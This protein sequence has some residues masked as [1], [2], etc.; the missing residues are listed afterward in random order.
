M[1]RYFFIFIINIIAFNLFAQ[2]GAYQ[3]ETPETKAERLKW[4]TDA[5][6]GMFIHW[7]AYSILDGEFGGKIQRDPKGEWIM[8]NLRIPIEDYKKEVVGKF[9]PS[10]F[11]AEKWVFVAKASGMKYMVVTAKHH[12]GFALFDS[13]VSDYDIIDAT[14]FKRDIIKELAE[15]CHR[16]G[17]RFGIYYSQAQDWYQPGGYLPNNRWDDG[18]IGNWNIYFNKIVKGQITELFTGYGQISILWWDSGRATQNKDV[19]DEVGANLVKLQPDIIVNNRLGG[20]LEGDFKTHEQQIPALYDGNEPH[21][22]CM[23]HNR[24]WSYRA[25]DNAWKSP[26]FI[27]KTLIHMASIGGNF[28]FNVGAQPDGEFP[29]ETYQALDYVGEWMRKNGEAIYGTSASPFYRLGWG[30]CTQKTVDGKTFLYL[31]VFDWSQDQT[32]FVPGLWSKID[33]AYLLDGNV[34]LGI[35]GNSEGKT[36]TNLPKKPPHEVASVIVLELLD[37]LRLKPNYVT[38]V[39]NQFQLLPTNA[40][41][42]IKPQFDEIPTIEG[43]KGDEYFDNWKNRHPHPQFKNTGNE[44]IWKVRVSTPKTYKIIATVATKTDENVVTFYSTK[45]DEVKI[46][47]PNTGGMDTFQKVEIG[48]IQL[49]K[50]VQKLIFTGGDKMDNWDFVRLKSIVL[51]PVD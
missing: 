51:E 27:L 4:F 35:K 17:L 5:R 50:G 47:L 14:P 44:A 28:L 2:R 20:E 49:K 39:N 30:E 22:L 31:H 8:Q 29:R 24:S 7:G 1:K 43:E 10:K 18:Q 26:Q 11:D 32:L 40:L 34:T 12:D 41:L 19:A 45:S 3:N 13:K 37:E 25:S 23:T 33:K 46:T 38:M 16:H 21:E 9:N 42:T 6:Y 15:A 48:T 36:I